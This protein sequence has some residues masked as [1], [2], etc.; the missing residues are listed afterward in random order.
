[1]ATL[2][3]L[4]MPQPGETIAE[5]TVIKW[6][7]A[8][9]DAVA[10]HEPVVELETAKAVYDY[11]SPIGGVVKK[12]LVEAG[13][14]QKV[15]QPLA[16]MECDDSAAKK[17][18]R[19]GVGLPVDASGQMVSAAASTSTA[20]SFT[21][22]SA[23]IPRTG[24]AERSASADVPRYA[25]FIRSLA[26]EHSLADAELAQIFG[27]GLGGRVRKEDVLAYVAQRTTG[28][29][30]HAPAMRAV[31]TSLP[32]ALPGSTRT[33]PDALRR[34]IAQNMMLSTR[35][36]PHAGTSV[37]VDMT[38]LLM[39]RDSAKYGFEKTHGVKLR[40][41][42]FFVFAVRE[43]LK[44][45]PACNNFYFIGSD[46]THVIEAHAHMNLGIAVGTPRGL[47]VPVLKQA[48]AKDFL[49]IAKESDGL[50]Q[51]ALAGKLTPDELTEATVTINNPGALGS[52]RG[53]QVI[54]YP[55]A[56]IVGFQAVVERAC[57]VN[58]QCVPRHIMA[59]DAS[60]DHRLIDGVEAVGF[61]MTCKA[62]LEN[63]GK[64]FTELS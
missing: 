21:N 28:A 8:V 61:L 63:P 39:L 48:D 1:M 6:L 64:A 13:R 19:L 5:G 46:G 2:V 56:I 37:D 22:V 24:R 53:N 17:Y 33:E 14:E 3:G 43:A 18:F 55:Q 25:P 44:K 23:N 35:T 47:V 32:T 52:V 30:T 36:I 4:P 54:P 29:I 11:E 41:A 31:A 9:G 42:P 40:L 34:R 58:G 38:E 62:L 45:H 50:M 12:I 60:F 15:G 59:L 16:V 57:V 20:S 51:K 10:E 26:Q 27:T 7:K 49:A